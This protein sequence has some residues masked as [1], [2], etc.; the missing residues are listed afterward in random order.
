MDFKLAISL[1]TIGLISVVLCFVFG[2]KMLTKTKRYS[3]VLRKD[4]LTNVVANSQ[5]SSSNKGY[6]IV[7]SQAN[8]AGP[9][10]CDVF[11]K[12][13]LSSLKERKYN[14]DFISISAKESV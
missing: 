7:D 2:V 8:N 1:L 6:F 13:D 4:I 11:F 12:S 3:K 9:N 10:H 5:S 14:S